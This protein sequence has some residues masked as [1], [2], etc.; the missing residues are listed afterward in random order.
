VRFSVERRRVT[1]ILGRNGAGKSSVLMA[2]A[3]FI[4]V[5]TSRVEIDGIRLSGPPYARARAGLSTVLNGRSLFPSLTVADNFALARVS[6]DEAFELFPELEKRLN[7]Q[8]GLLS[9][10][11]QQMLT[12]SRGLLRRPAVLLVDELTIGL[13]PAVAAR[14]IEAL[15][16]KT[17]EFDI[18]TVVVEQHLHLAQAIADEVLVM[19]EGKVRIQL[20]GRELRER[21]DEI[22]RVYLG[23]PEDDRQHEADAP[24]E[25]AEPFEPDGSSVNNSKPRSHT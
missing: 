19:G 3:G 25:P 9:G 8:A 13:S 24:R 2:I 14:L 20:S 12:V 5:D 23:R 4:G 6:T 11:E 17:Q 10:G 18:A 22:Q 7:V 16:R 15:I 1:V 21:E